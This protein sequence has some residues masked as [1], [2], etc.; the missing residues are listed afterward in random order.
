MIQTIKLE[1]GFDIE[2]KW[3][4]RWRPRWP[5]VGIQ[6]GRQ[7]ASKDLSDHKNNLDIKHF[8]FD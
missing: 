4:G 1:Y 3:E 5:S 8:Y 6:D 2:G 7:L